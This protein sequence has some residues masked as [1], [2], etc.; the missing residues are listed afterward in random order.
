[1]VANHKKCS[2]CVMCCGHQT[3][4]WKEK[5]TENFIHLIERRRK[6]K[7]RKKNGKQDT[8]VI[9]QK[10]NKSI[11]NH[12]ITCWK[13]II[14]V[15]RDMQKTKSYR[16]NENKDMENTCMYLATEHGPKKSKIIVILKN[17]QICNLIG[18]F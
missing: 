8:K 16:K 11:T 15:T 7:R 18:R 4:S 13:I 5:E 14:C 9:G 1:M 3:S 17:W 2:T 10:L 12:K 6:E